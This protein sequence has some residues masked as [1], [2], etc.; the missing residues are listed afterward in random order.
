MLLKLIF[1]AIQLPFIPIKDLYSL[2]N[3]NNHLLKLKQLSSYIIKLV[4][5]KDYKRKKT[6]DIYFLLIISNSITY[7]I[8]R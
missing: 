8:I 5:I 3:I 7:I 2:T 1:D 6:I 4:F